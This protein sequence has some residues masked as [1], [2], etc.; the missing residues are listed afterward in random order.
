[1]RIFSVMA[2]EL[3]AISRDRKTLVISILIP[4]L[5]MPVLMF[6]FNQIMMVETEG[7]N[8]LSVSA[9][10]VGADEII[11]ALSEDPFVFY[12][13]NDPM[14]DIRE[15]N[16][17]VHVELIRETEN[18][19]KAIIYHGVDTSSLQAAEVVHHRISVI[20]NLL[21]AR[22]LNELGI[23]ESLLNKVAIE[24]HAVAQD[25]Q[26][27]L[28]GVFFAIIVLSWAAIGAMYPASDV[29]A[30]ERERGTI[31]V[32]LM[33]PAKNLQ[34]ITGKFLS[35]YIVSL[36]TLVLATIATLATV[37]IGR[38]DS[39]MI[40]LADN[41]AL[42]TSAIV[43]L[44]L[45]TTAIITATE[46]FASAYARSFR[47]AQ[48]YL[49]PIFLLLIMPG[50]ALGVAPSISTK[51]FLYYVPFINNTLVI[52]ELSLGRLDWLHFPITILSS[53]IFSVILLFFT[54]QVLRKEPS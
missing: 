47:E 18:Q 50:V 13:T 53:L 6:T 49:T 20:N 24:T 1:M 8:N 43:V 52:N 16:L 2:K 32:L 19:Y 45:S 7:E 38:I 9:P 27:N 28:S 46:M 36:I 29:T 41:V 33:T 30:G 51:E 40:T 26:A 37:K 22:G 4:I 14:R 17:S 39:L 34:L 42:I 25:N 35:V 5:M 54:S 10:A 11:A 12:Q 48:T 23:D 21:A 31:D 44:I 3:L 15:R